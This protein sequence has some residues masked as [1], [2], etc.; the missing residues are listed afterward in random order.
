MVMA[1]RVLLN[2]RQTSACSG[3]DAAAADTI[4]WLEMPGCAR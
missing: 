1:S 2:K 3:G 4:G